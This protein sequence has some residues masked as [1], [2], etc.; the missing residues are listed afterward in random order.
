[1]IEIS[2]SSNDGEIILDF[3]A[4]SGTTGQATLEAN[5]GDAGN[6]RFVLVQLPEPTPDDSS[7]RSAGFQTVADIGK[8]LLRR[9][10]AMMGEQDAGKLNAQGDPGE[11]RGFRLFMLSE[12]NLKSWTGL[13]QVDAGRYISQMELHN[14]PLVAD[15]DAENVVWEIAFREGLSLNARVETVDG[16]KNAVYRVLDS[17]KSQRITIC[18]DDK[19]DAATLTTLALSKDDTFICRDVAL[20]D[21]LAA[22][23]ALQC[24]LKTI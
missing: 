4:G 9:V 10:I 22:N 24:R 1:M 14:D 8:E 6:R 21:E 5:R 19:V 20:D 15:W 3:F 18:L 11:D 7:A 23:L 12:S 2:T 17:D 13:S 16:V